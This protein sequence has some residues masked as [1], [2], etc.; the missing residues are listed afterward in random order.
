MTRYLLP[1]LS[2]A[3]LLA[4]CVQPP[5][6]ATAGAAA[7][8]C[9]AHAAQFAVGYTS[10]DALSDEVRRRSGARLVRLLRPGQV[11]TMEYSGERINLELDEGNRVTGVRCG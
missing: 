11:T 2:C 1:S 8:G 7:A 5:S 10:T 3:L 4:A 9:D 6:L